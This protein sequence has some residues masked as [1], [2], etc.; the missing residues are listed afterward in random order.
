[1]IKSF[2]L[3]YSA[4]VSRVIL[5]PFDWQVVWNFDSRTMFLDCSCVIIVRA[6]SPWIGQ[7]RTKRTECLRTPW[8]NVT[9]YVYA[10]SWLLI[11]LTLCSM[12]EYVICMWIFLVCLCESD[13]CIKIYIITNVFYFIRPRHVS[14]YLPLNFKIAC[15][16]LI[17][18]T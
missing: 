2:I 9:L 18:I 10:Y 13:T 17:N 14:A 11:S 6:T 1:M 4:I 5:G 12:Y 16:V 15:V 3:S 7:R 8:Q